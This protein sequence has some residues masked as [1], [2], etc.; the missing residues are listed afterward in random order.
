[1]KH[2]RT[3]AFGLYLICALPA[4]GHAALDAYHDMRLDG[5][6][7]EDAALIG[8]LMGAVAAASWPLYAATKAWGRWG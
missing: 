3:R 7:T 6:T 4:F 1:M 8:G 5:R 2:L